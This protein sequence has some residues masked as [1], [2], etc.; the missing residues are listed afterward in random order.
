MIIRALLALAIGVA[1]VAGWAA[2]ETMDNT[3]KKA[4]KVS[5]GAWKEIAVLKLN[6]GSHLLEFCPDGKTLASGSVGG[7][8]QVGQ[9]QQGEITL[10]DV[11]TQKL[12][13]TLRGHKGAIAGLAFTADGKTLISVCHEGLLKRWD[14]ARGK[15]RS[16][17]QLSLSEIVNAAFSPD[18]KTLATSVGNLRVTQAQLSG[19]VQF[20]NV[21]TGRKLAA[22][23]A[24]GALV[25]HLFYS[26]SG[27]TLVTFG[28]TFNKNARVAPDG[29]SN[30]FRGETKFWNTATRRPKPIKATGGSTCAFSPDS[31]VFVT[32][33]Y[34][35]ASRGFKIKFF[36]LVKKTARST[37]TGHKGMLYGLICSRD[38]KILASASLDRTV[39][40]WDMATTRELATLKGHRS[41]VSAVAFSPDG[42]TLASVSSGD[43][44]LRLWSAAK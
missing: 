24:H 12:R 13:H 36:D 25:N 15:V 2:A 29:T 20:W 19:Q 37:K 14:V 38:G 7:V 18:R 31:N 42:K 28:T 8:N 43:A 22:I 41:W 11:A 33:T 17:V 4:A 9:F 34:D 35:Q 26:P 27:K 1:W 32:D 44:T 16:T 3:P 21:G 30:A 40:L 39:K 5:S 23:P 10:W 6:Q